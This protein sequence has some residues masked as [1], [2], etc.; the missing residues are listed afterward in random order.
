MP[1]SQSLSLKVIWG[2][3]IVSCF[4]Y[5]LAPV[6]LMFPMSLSAADTLRWPPPGFSLR[7]YMSLLQNGEFLFALKNSLVLASIVTGLA[8]VIGFCAAFYID[9][10]PA[11]RRELT[12]TYLTLPLLVPHLVIGLALLIVFSA[13]GYIGSW[14]G[15]TIGHLVVTLPFAVRILLT[16]LS[17]LPANLEDAAASLGASPARCVWLI[18]IPLMGR[19]IVATMLIVFL[20][21]FDEVIVSLFV[22]G[23][24]VHTLPVL[25]YEYSERRTDPS[26]AA[27]SGL[28]ILTT[29]ALVIAVDRLIGFRR[30]VSGA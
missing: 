26:V 30:A 3:I 12:T 27:A 4:T 22:V 13:Y 24:K 28:I 19:G 29:I 7:W 8:L 23:P 2:I 14:T 17:T 1:G 21:S 16:S 11:W 5:L 10:G 20:V 25:L 18:T 15:M 9:R 6:L